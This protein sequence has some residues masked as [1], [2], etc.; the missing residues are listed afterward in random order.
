[1]D[2]CLT[3]FKE[4]NEAKYLT[5]YHYY[6]FYKPLF[7]KMLDRSICLVLVDEEQPNVIWSFLIY[8]P[9]NTIHYAYTKYNFR[10]HGLMRALVAAA[11]INPK[12][13]N[14]TFNTR[15]SYNYKQREDT[16]LTY[17]SPE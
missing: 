10:N 9:D 4:S 17:R 13:F 1:M 7:R 5:N 11:D 3:S 8:S 15:S 14:Y 6:G 16:T 2:A 12:E